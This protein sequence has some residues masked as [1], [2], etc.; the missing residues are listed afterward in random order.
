MADRD[1]RASRHPRTVV[2]GTDSA[3]VPPTRSHTD[4]PGV[5]T[6]VYSVAPERQRWIESEL[7][8][9]RA[10]VQIARSVA[11]VI[12]ALCEDPAPLPTVLVVDIDSLVPVDLLQLHEI[13]ERGWC[14][15][16]VALGRVAPALRAS[17]KIDKVLTPP[18]VEDALLDALDWHRN[19]SAARTVPLPLFP[20]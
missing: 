9:A 5:R 2:R 16:I 4:G 13:R 18:F 11:H 8:R 15:T 3:F 17:L 19:Q 20:A 12:R 7:V 10:I 1:R 6:I 14:G